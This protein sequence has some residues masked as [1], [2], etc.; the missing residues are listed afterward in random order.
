MPNIKEIFGAKLE[1][2]SGKF[3]KKYKDKYIKKKE[4]KPK[5]V[6]NHIIS[7]KPL[8]GPTKKLVPKKK[9]IA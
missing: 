8:N 4:T 2:S 5:F 9:E 1:H 6:R 7:P 3:N